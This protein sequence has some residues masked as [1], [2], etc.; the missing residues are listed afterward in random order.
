MN[1][2]PAFTLSFFVNIL[3]LFISI[4]GFSIGIY[5]YCIKN[6]RSL[7]HSVHIIK[8]NLALI[9]TFNLVQ[10]A[11]FCLG[12]KYLDDFALTLEDNN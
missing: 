4:F 10:I 7:K 9:I 1:W 6:T 2:T 11:N 12:Y 5:G 8:W 3:T